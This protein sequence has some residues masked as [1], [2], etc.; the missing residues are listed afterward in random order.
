VLDPGLIAD[1][2]P[3]GEAMTDAGFVLTDESGT[4]EARFQR[5]GFDEEIVVPVDLI[6][7]EELGVGDRCCQSS[8]R[9]DRSSVV[10]CTSLAPSKAATTASRCS[11]MRASSSRS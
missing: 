6:V 3:L 2:P 10:S 5:A 9:I 11:S 7:P 4:W 8:S 1:I